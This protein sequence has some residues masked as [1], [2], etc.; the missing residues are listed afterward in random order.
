MY[1]LGI[2]NIILVSCLISSSTNTSICCAIIN[3]LLWNN[4]KEIK[5]KVNDI[6]SSI[7]YNL[8]LELLLS[9]DAFNCQCLSTVFFQLKSCLHVHIYYIPFS[10][11]IIFY[12]FLFGVC[13]IFC[14][15]IFPVF[16]HVWHVFFRF[17]KISR[18][19]FSI[20]S[21]PFYYL[22][23]P[24]LFLASLLSFVQQICP[25]NI[26]HIFLKW[27]EI[28]PYPCLQVY[29]SSISLLWNS[30]HNFFLAYFDLLQLFEFCLSCN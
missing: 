14:Y 19:L 10:S 2:V 27:S 13:M 17:Y 16:L 3:F 12:P 9:C 18:G 5:L 4:I 11:P 6:K 25:Y 30:T 8:D 26:P 22:S 24:I 7:H 21:F 15:L 20:S 23:L 1:F 28:I 29:S